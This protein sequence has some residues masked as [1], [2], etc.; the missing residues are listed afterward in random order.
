MNIHE[1]KKQVEKLKRIIKKLGNTSFSSK[2]KK[3]RFRK[4]N[5]KRLDNCIMSAFKTV[6]LVVLM[7]KPINRFKPHTHND[8]LEVIEMP[9]G[10]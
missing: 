4:K 7:S 9:N 1:K 6:D 2:S 5:F 8:N 10:K 3:K